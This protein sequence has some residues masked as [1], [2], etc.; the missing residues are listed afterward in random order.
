[1]TG[2]AKSAQTA[3]LD[4]ADVGLG[5]TLW[6][7]LYRWSGTSGTGAGQ[8]PNDDGTLP[9]NVVEVSTGG[10]VRKSVASGDWSTST[11]GALG[12]ASSKQV[13]KS[14]GSAISWTA[15][16]ASFGEVVAWGLHSA[17]VSGTM[18]LSGPLTDSA[19][20]V[21]YRTISDGDTFQFDANNPIIVRIGDPARV[22]DSTAG[23][24]RTVPI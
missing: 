18:I 3:I 15:A 23:S 10:Y 19:G 20:A 13:P 24:Q 12:T 17:S 4:D 1:M 21:T 7:S 2:F 9:T 14:G 11:A 5:R 16:G 6:L 8:E 22:T